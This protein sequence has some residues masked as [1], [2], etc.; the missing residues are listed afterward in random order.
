MKT[1]F[2]S[3]DDVLGSP[4]L[5]ELTALRPAAQGQNRVLKST[6]IEDSVYHDLR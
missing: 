6:R 5:Q 3:I 1:R 2:R 4:F